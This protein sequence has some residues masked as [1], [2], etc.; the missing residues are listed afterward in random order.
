[1][2]ATG[3]HDTRN[4]YDSIATKQTWM[5]KPFMMQLLAVICQTTFGRL[6]PGLGVL[7]NPL[8]Q[9]DAKVRSEVEK[10]N[11]E[12]DAKYLDMGVITEPQIAR[13]LVIDEVYSVIDE[14]H[15]K[16][17]ELMVTPDDDNN[18]DSETLPAGN[19]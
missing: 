5:L 15:I 19:E 14:A 17:L 13:Q 18:P 2:N 16:Q 11:A 8:W 1:M 12:R 9:L 6:I 7:L 3:E 4:Y 10:A